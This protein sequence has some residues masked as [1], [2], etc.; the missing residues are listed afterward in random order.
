MSLI[1]IDGHV[2][3]LETLESLA[4]AVS[5]LS[6]AGVRCNGIPISPGSLYAMI[7]VQDRQTNFALC[8]LKR[9][10]FD[11]SPDAYPAIATLSGRHG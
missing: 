4:L 1:E 10:G 9:N 2:G 7:E 3:G 5:T 8:L 6:R 11:V